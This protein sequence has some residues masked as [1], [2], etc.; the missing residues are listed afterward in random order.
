MKRCPNIVEG[1]DWV[2]RQTVC[3]PKARLFALISAFLLMLLLLVS[4]AAETSQMDILSHM[5]EEM[6]REGFEDF[7]FSSAYLPLVHNSAD[8]INK[9]LKSHALRKRIAT[10]IGGKFS[11]VR[12]PEYRLY[13]ITP[14]SK[15]SFEGFPEE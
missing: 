8:A 5:W 12:K 1:E 14:D 4:A 2:T 7:G 13:L 11:I 10:L 9:E 3:R 6:P 15:A